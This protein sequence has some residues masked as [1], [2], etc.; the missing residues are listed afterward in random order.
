VSGTIVGLPKPEQGDEY[1]VYLSIRKFVDCDGGIEGPDTWVEVE[2]RPP[3]VNTDGSDIPYGP[4]TTY[5]P[6][7]LPGAGEYEIITWA[8]GAGTLPPFD[9]NIA[10]DGDDTQNVD[11]GTQINFTPEPPPSTP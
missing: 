8:G 4:D 6:I 10:A 11:L 7:I 5:G 3:F 9:I 1:S 2:S